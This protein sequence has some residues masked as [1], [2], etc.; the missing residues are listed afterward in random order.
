MSPALSMKIAFHVAH[1][2][3]KL[4][5]RNAQPEKKFEFSN[6]RE[7]TEKTRIFD[8]WLA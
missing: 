8:I 4:Q 1:W 3:K 2:Q 6:F 5:H 7:S